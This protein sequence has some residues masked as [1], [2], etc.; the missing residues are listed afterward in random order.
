MIVPDLSV[1]IVSA[2]SAHFL[3]PCLE[4]LADER[5]RLADSRREPERHEPV[6][7]EK[8]KEKEQIPAEPLE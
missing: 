4:A 8:L 2:N 5:E 6:S 3:G 7:G 1:I